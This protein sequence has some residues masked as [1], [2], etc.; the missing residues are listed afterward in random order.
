[1]TA[2]ASRKTTTCGWAVRVCDFPRRPVPD[3]PNEP[4]DLRAALDLRSGEPAI[5]G[6]QA[7]GAEMFVPAP[8]L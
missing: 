8:A 2:R 6:A 5:Y 7:L 1:M 3:K 4:L